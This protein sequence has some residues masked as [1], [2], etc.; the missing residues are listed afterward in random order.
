MTSAA[1]HST[2]KQRV[3]T[4]WIWWFLGGAVALADFT[5]KQLVRISMPHG[6]QIPLTD[7]FNLV[8]ASNAGAAFSMLADAG[9]WQRY[10]FTVVAVV[11][12]AWLVWMLSSALTRIEA[13]AYSLILG[14]AIGNAAD[15]IMYGVVTDFLDFHWRNWHWPAFNLADV[16][17][18]VGAVAL[19]AA[20]FLGTAGRTK[21]QPSSNR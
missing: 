8:H 13:L 5:T 10:F 18:C 7:F 15:R 4:G 12:S 3:A 2:F 6:D 21:P 19:M 11:V 9:G 17:I 14:G 16:A 1:M 20:A